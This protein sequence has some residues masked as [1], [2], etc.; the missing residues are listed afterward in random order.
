MWFNWLW[1]RISLSTCSGMNS[2]QLEVLTIHSVSVHAGS[3]AHSNRPKPIASSIASH[4]VPVQIGKLSLSIELQ[5]YWNLAVSA[6]CAVEQGC[7]SLV[8]LLM[9][10][11]IFNTPT[12]A[13]QT[14]TI[15]LHE[16]WIQIV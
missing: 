5:C 1:M 8:K 16:D 9:Q 3:G 10:C 4:L 15:N 14:R 11:K 12:S 13:E 6:C 7:L 2:R